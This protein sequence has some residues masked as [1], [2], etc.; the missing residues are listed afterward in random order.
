[1]KKPTILVLS[2][3]GEPPLAILHSDKDFRGMIRSQMAGLWQ[4][5]DVTLVSGQT[6]GIVGYGDIGRAVAARVRPLGM[7]VVAV[8]RQVSAKDKPDALVDQVYSSDRR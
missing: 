4:P 3:A 7:N 1:M 8:K 2:S 6:V 5:F